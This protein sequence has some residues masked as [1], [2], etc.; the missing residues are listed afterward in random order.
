M[1]PPRVLLTTVCRPLGEAHGDGPSVGY[2]LLH[3]QVTRAQGIFSPRSSQGSFGL[4]YIAEN[5]SCPVTVLQ[6]PTRRELVRE[7]GRGYD[8]VGVAFV[9]ATFHR[10]QEV[11][12]LVRRHAPQARVVLGGYGTVLPDDVLAPYGDAICREEGVAFMRRLL[13]EPDVPGVHRHPL[14]VSHLRI[15]GVETSR[16]GM[17]FAGLGCPNGCDFCCTSHF[18]GRRHLRLLP[19][20]RDIHAVVRRYLDMDPGISLAVLDEDFLLNRKRAMEFRDCVL[21][22]GEPFSLF[23]FAS[24]KA[25]SQYTVTEILEMGIDGVWI[26]YEGSRSGYAKQSGRPFPELAAELQAHGIT[27]LASMIVGFPYQTPD[28]IRAER[29]ALLACEPTLCQFLIYGPTPGTPFYER[30][31]REGLMEPHLASDLP[32]YLRSC[33]GFTAMVRHPTMQGPDIEA[34][35]RQSFDEDFHRLGPIIYR[36]VATWLRGHEKL[37]DAPQPFLR[38]KAARFAREIRKAYPVFLAGRLFGP[39]RGVR[40]RIADLERRAHAALGP[41]TAKERLLTAAAVVMAAATSLRLRLGIERHPKLLRNTYRMADEPLPSRAWRQVRASLRGMSAAVELR[42]SRTIWVSIEGQ[43][44]AQGADGLAARLSRALAGGRERLVLDLSRLAG[45]EQPAAHRLVERLH[46]FAPRIHVLGPE[47][48]GFLSLAA[49]LAL[50][51][52][53]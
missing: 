50:V 8:V 42:A 25:L 46:A 4:D 22:S 51:E 9:L 21:E 2:E 6:Y 38:A 23:A 13:Q 41:P 27:V 18:F 34:A 3:G 52:R 10:M 31:M 26:G 36:T 45:L 24:I 5:L 16:T 35:Q 30:V 48:T 53:S 15:F 14:A 39:S 17:V 37:R 44:P 7:L 12:A 20:G 28:I 1:P 40:R 29:E 11:V 33:T 49:L 43:L 19:T 32:R 47:A